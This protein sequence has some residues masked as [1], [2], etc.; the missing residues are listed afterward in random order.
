[1]VTLNENIFDAAATQRV[2]V[3]GDGAEG[4]TLLTTLRERHAQGQT[5]HCESYLGA[6][7]ELSKRPVRAVLAVVSGSSAR[8]SDAV[9]GLR[10]AAGDATRIWLCCTTATEPLARSVCSAG[11]DDYL[12]LPLHTKDLDR[13]LGRAHVDVRPRAD[14]GDCADLSALS[15][16]MD[17]SAQNPAQALR[18]FAESVRDRLAAKG[19]SLV[20]DGSM[21]ATGEAVTKPVLSTP[22]MRDGGVVG[23]LLVGERTDGPFDPADAER[24]RHLGTIVG[25]LLASASRQ[26]QWQRLAQ[27]DEVSGLPNRR[28]LLEQ[29]PAVLA[30]AKEERFPVTVLLFDVDDFKRYNDKHGHDAGDEIIRVVGRLFRQHCREQD[31]V[32]RY[33]GDEFAVAFW[34][35]EGSRVA[36]SSHPGCALNVL[37]RFTAALRQHAFAKFGGEARLTV[38]GGLAT[39]PWD[40]DNTESL[41]SKADEALLAAKRAGKNKVLVMGAEAK[42]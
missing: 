17:A 25:H 9:A 1:M 15:A 27:T 16:A 32:V 38:S 10:M 6:I 14:R 39:Y 13:A 41:I 19:V 40:G 28:H 30:R 4:R 33:G 21:T 31:I 36:G 3:V 7:A 34:D 23:Q 22:L 37:D 11:A 18:V 20:I 29:L 5:T 26:R 12:V 35:A 42:V 24:L 2:L 8:L